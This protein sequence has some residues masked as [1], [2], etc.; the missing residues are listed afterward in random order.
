MA[1]D[2]DLNEPYNDSDGVADRSPVNENRA[3]LP[4]DLNVQPSDEEYIFDLNV[5][6]SLED[7]CGNDVEN[8]TGGHGLDNNIH[9]IFGSEADDIGTQDDINGGD[10]DMHDLFGEE[11]EDMGDALNEEAI[12]V[13]EIQR[14]NNKRSFLDNNQRKLVSH[15]LLNTSYN[16][17]LCKGIVKTLASY[18]SVSK[19]VI[20]RIWRQIKKTA[21]PCHKKT[22]NCGRKRIQI[23]FD[24]MRNVSLAKRSTLRSLQTVL[25]LKTKTTLLKCIKEGVLRRHSNVLK[26]YLNDSN[27]KARI[28]FCLDMLEE[29][30]IPHDPVFKPMYN[31]VH[32]DEKWFYITKKS[33][34]YYLL[35]D[36]DEPHRMCRNKNYIGKV[37]FL[38]VVARPRFDDDGNETFS[39]KIGCF[40]IVHKVAAQ[41]SS[42][43]RPAGTLE[44]KPIISIN[45]EVT[46][47]MYINEVLPA[48]KEKWPQEH[49]HETIYI[50]QDNAPCHVPL[51]DEE[52]CRAAAD[53]GFDIRLTF[54][55]PNSPDLNVLDLGFFS[56]IQSLQQQEV[57]NSVDALIEAVQKIFDAFSAQSSNNIF[58]TLQSCMTEIMKVKGSNNY[59]IPHMEK[60]KLL[61]RGMLPTQLTCDPEL[62]Q[63]TFEYLY[64]VDEM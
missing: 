62:F 5:A 55:P 33:S 38:V 41:R 43:N 25:G 35:G 60:E 40:P 26:P 31:V 19:D 63:E 24:K 51:D 13:E 32:I 37:M 12:I 11:D 8:V 18:F 53:G 49:A 57:T 58:L 14:S 47:M 6:P 34:S 59:K 52:F 45:R 1:F 2:I 22:K 48:L 46:R 42:I 56:A 17:K 61:R 27:K 50:Q 29:S 20:Y 21:D 9:D 28:E 30:S 23:D 64:N 54:Q 7:E 39:G 4:I 15:L 16:G 3:M 44:T 10:E 36:E